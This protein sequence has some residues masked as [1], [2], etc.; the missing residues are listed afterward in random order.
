M[1]APSTRSPAT[2]PANCPTLYAT[3]SVCS[4]LLLVVA[5]SSEC[6]KRPGSR[7]LPLFSSAVLPQCYDRVAFPERIRMSANSLCRVTQLVFLLVFAAS[8]VSAADTK[9]PLR[10][11]IA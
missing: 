2:T 9:P 6:R 1:T 11:V 4:Y 3:Y 10:V 7:Q 5:K 8:T